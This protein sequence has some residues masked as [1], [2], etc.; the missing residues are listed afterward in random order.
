M[1]KDDELIKIKD[2][3]GVDCL[4]LYPAPDMVSYDR[5]TPGI[6][7]IF[8]HGLRDGRTCLT[9]EQNGCKISLCK[10]EIEQLPRF[11]ERWKVD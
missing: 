1:Q 3:Q 8:S 9:I 2:L 5:A 6:K 7:T 10:T 11:V 4:K